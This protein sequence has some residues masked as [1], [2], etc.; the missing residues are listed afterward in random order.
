MSK[1]WQ[2]LESAYRKTSYWLLEG[3]VESDRVM[4]L[5]VDEPCPEGFFKLVGGKPWAL[6]TSCNP[7]S[8]PLDTES[9]ALLYRKL[10]DRV[11]AEGL[12]HLAAVG[13]ELEVGWM[14][15]MLL[16]W[17]LEL[18]DALVFAKTLGQRAILAEKPGESDCSEG[19][20]GLFYTEE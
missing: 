3:L 11:S 1:H 2:E 8:M 18:S 16:V 12:Q 19:L 9:N 5:R 20:V 6:L 13:V 4:V 14:E 17:P 15:P 7:G 10:R